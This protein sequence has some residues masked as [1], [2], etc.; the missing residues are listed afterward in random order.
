MG[1]QTGTGSSRADHEVTH[2]RW[3]AR[4]DPE[5]VWG[6]GT[7][8]GQLRARRRADLIMHGAELTAGKRALEIGCGTGMFT[9][10]FVQSGASIVA[11]DISPDLLERAR[12]RN[13][14][15]ERV[16]FLAGRFE[17]CEID[18]PFDAVLGSSVLH[19]LDT[20][21]AL[22]RI[23]RLLKPGG[24]FSFA[25]PNYLN[26]QVF[27]ERRFRAFPVFQYTSPDETAFVRW[28]LARTLRR[29]GFVDISIVPFDWLHPRT[30]TRL[31]G[32]VRTAGKVVEHLPV[33][34]EFSGSL[35]IRAWSPG[36]PR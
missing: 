26:P 12:R 16:V 20:E 22:P 25:E 19:H 27:L 3:L 21:V 6:W 31:I 33:L 7:P 34:R 29:S 30:P 10:L 36:S 15:P 14:S 17:D 9:E 24:C 23:R 18:G 32:A 4:H 11:V 2:G 35:Y 5:K 28:P 13:L 8:G 1:E